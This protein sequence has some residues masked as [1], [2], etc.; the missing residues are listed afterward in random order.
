MLRAPVMNR[1]AS[2]LGALMLVLML[3]TGGAA[4]AAER[5]DCIPMT[6]QAEGHFD[7]DGDEAP[8][9]PD[10]GVAHHHAGCS[11]HHLNAPDSVVSALVA[12]PTAVLLLERSDTGTRG[13]EPDGE[14][15][16]PI[17]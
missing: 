1:W 14:L 10:Q 8:A 12:K 7:G 15:R 4:H 6:V 16:P 3:W 9:G 13:N 5:F 2:L 17:A 11:G